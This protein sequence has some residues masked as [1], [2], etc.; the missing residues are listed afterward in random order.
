[1]KVH[2]LRFFFFTFMV[3]T[4][5]TVRGLIQTKFPEFMI[6]YDAICIGIAVTYISFIYE[7]GK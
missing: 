1:M 3:F 6:A 5:L 7:S 2:S 4:F